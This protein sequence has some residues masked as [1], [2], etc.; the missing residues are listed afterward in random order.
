MRFLSLIELARLSP[1]QRGA[2]AGYGER[3]QRL[4]AS[5]MP[6][7]RSAAEA[8]VGEAYAAA[9]LPP[10]E[11]V[12]W[13]GG[14]RELAQAW[15]SG[16]AAAGDNVRSRVVDLV[17][18]RAEVGV[19]RAIGLSVRTALA[20]EPRLTRLPG[21]TASIVEAVHRDCAALRPRLRQRVA[22]LFSRPRRK[23]PPS[24]VESSAALLNA[25]SLGALQFFHDV[26][27]LE[28]QTRALAGLWQLADQVSWIVP[29]QR[30]CWL[31]ERP[32]L[33]AQDANGRLHAAKGPAVRYGDGW[34]AYAWKGVLVP[35]WMI[36]RS[37]QINVRKI[38][39]AN[40]P[41]VRRCMIDLMTPERFIA[42]GGAYRVSQDDT[43]ILWRQRWRWETWAAVEVVNG[44]PEA[45]G[46]CKHYFLQVPADVRSPREAVAWT[47][48]LTEQQYRPRVR[49]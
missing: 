36:E 16:Q 33:I 40:D 24:F 49:T 21:F 15:S 18:R 10:P 19:D 17:C 25:P 3:W 23:L 26:C 47:Y 46:V 5:T 35:S 29:H 39:S 6:A 12:V 4:R 13:T 43:G 1:E 11:R 32:K 27:G 22:S 28:R 44:T 30:V 31:A 41:Q 9:G 48:G 45:N 7:D 20:Q 42:Q 37:E 2:L 38:A 14:P 8:G 34:T